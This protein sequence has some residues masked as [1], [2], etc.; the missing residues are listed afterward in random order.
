V[1]GGQQV[2]GDRSADG[3]VVVRPVAG[4]RHAG[5]GGDG[6]HEERGAPP[7]DQRQRRGRR[8]RDRQ[9]AEAGQADARARLGA[10]GLQTPVPEQHE[11]G[12]E[13]RQGERGVGGGGGTEPVGDRPVRR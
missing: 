12:R 3:H 10:H 8:Q 2:E 4:Q 6:E 1:A 5:A 11:G 7:G 9:R 13:H